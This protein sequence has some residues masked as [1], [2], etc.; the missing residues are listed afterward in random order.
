MRDM[1]SRQ[2][3][4]LA[5]GKGL[6]KGV[7]LFLAASAAVALLAAVLGFFDHDP[8]DEGGPRIIYQPPAGERRY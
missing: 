2:L 3:E 5:K 7:G 8:A 6:L 1:G 4:E